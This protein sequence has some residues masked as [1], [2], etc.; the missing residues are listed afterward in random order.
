MLV[1]DDVEEELLN[2]STS[3]DQ[4]TLWS[5]HQKVKKSFIQFIFSHS[6]KNTHFKIFVENVSWSSLRCFL[7][8]FFF[9]FRVIN[10]P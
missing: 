7:F 8:L 6:I 3:K 1:G 5:L 2:K 4:V 10:T 9:F